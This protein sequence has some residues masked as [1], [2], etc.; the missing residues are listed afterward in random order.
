MLI[1]LFFIHKKQLAFTHWQKI[2]TEGDFC[3]TAHIP[4]SY[5]IAP[6]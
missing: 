4:P 6:G 3:L 2:A 5:A 1:K